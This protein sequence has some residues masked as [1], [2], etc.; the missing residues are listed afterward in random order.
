MSPFDI[1]T[2][3]EPS[4]F[5]RTDGGGLRWECILLVPKADN[6]VGGGDGQDARLPDSPCGLRVSTHTTHR[7][8]LNL[9]VQLPTEMRVTGRG[10]ALGNNQQLWGCMI[11]FS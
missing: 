2:V 10:E 7:K 5:I 6:S 3:A 11:V 4:Q 8:F 9:C 1:S